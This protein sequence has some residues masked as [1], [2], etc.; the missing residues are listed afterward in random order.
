VLLYGNFHILRSHLLRWLVDFGLILLLL[1][2]VVLWFGSWFSFE[3]TVPF[4]RCCALRL[5]YGGLRFAVCGCS[6]PFAYVCCAARAAGLVR[7]RA[8]TVPFWVRLPAVVAALLVGSGSPLRYRYAGYALHFR[9]FA[10]SVYRCCRLR[11]VIVAFA[12][13]GIAC[14]GF[15]IRS[16]RS[17][18][19]VWLLRWFTLL[20]CTFD[21]FVAVW[22]VVALIRSCSLR[23]LRLL[24][25][26]VLV[27]LL[28]LLPLIRY[29]LLPLFGSFVTLR[30]CVCCALPGSGWIG[31]LLIVVGLPVYVYMLTLRFRLGST[32]DFDSGSFCYV[33][34]WFLFPLPRC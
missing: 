22:L 29:T 23:S 6:S 8:A 28:R 24:R 25:V 7:S 4:V 10:S 26:A 31:S 15:C 34:F 14:V 16:S 30:V 17:A 33:R 9:Q 1:L 18:G 21:C 2:F 20:V 13:R 19:S 3:S 27:A 32:F 11:Y 12:G 5:V